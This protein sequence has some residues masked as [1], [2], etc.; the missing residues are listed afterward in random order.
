MR[1]ALLAAFLSAAAP[2]AL[3]QAEAEA[4]GPARLDVGSPD[5]RIGVTVTTSEYGEPLYSVSFGGETVIEPSRLGMRF[6][7]R[8]PFEDGLE[9]EDVGRSSADETYELPW[10]ER[11]VVRD[12]HEAMIVTFAETEGP[13]AFDVEFRVSDAGVAYRYIFTDDSGMDSDVVVTDEL[14]EFTIPQD[15]TT[16]FHIPARQWNRY[17]YLYETTG[18]E[19]MA[20]VHTPVTF[21]LAD[22]THLALHEAALTDYS[23]MSLTLKRNN[24]LEADL[25]P[26]HA[27]GKVHKDGAFKTPWRV[28]QVAGSA[29]DLYNGT[30]IYLNLNE[31]NAL[32]DVSWVEPGKYVGIWWGMHLKTQTW[33]S[34]PSHG[35]TTENT[36][37]MIDFAAEH[38]FDG[39]LVEGWNVGWDGDWYNAG[40]VMDFT[41]SYPDFDLERVAAYALDKGVRIVGHHETV[42]NIGRYEDQMEE[43]FDLYEANGIRQV[44]TGHVADAGDI[45]WEDEDGVQQHGF[46]E[47]QYSVNYHV[48][49]LEAAAKR[50]ISLNPHE[51]VKDTGVRRTY[52]NWISREGARGSEY[53]AWGTPP[54]PPEHTVILPYTRMLSGPFDYTPGIFDLRPNEGLSGE[55]LTE[56]SV[57]SRIET[58]LAKQLALYVTIYSPIQMAADLPENYEANPGP[59]QFI[60]DVAADWEESVALAGEVGDYLVIARKAKGTEGDERG[61]WFLGAT[62]DEEARRVRVPLDFL[63][64]GVT[65]TAQV[66][67]DGP[68]AHWETNPY[69][70]TIDEIEVDARGAF[71]L[72]MAPGGG[73]AVRFVPQ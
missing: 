35:A 39:I 51:P 8:N 53:D 32:G 30:D 55:Q 3:A 52:P 23:G 17:E 40:E 48:R 26:H 24:I 70:V 16:A 67:R 25:A 44:K 22:G 15:G 34:G 21:R 19:D 50:K 2:A 29:A 59:F 60:K 14:S 9:I 10:G 41:Q 7:E 57:E 47:G 61:E 69:P 12:R 31:P 5:G 72:D 6:M 33:G 27:G 46:H 43:A 49:A 45:T 66:Y 63:D 4:E 42:G 62:T 20:T 65:Y 37:A 54:N 18:L 1:S 56:N 71:N 58:T 13:R 28:I 68:G 36:L 38:G 11:A 64:E 73:T